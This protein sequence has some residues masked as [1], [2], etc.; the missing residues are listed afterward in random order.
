MNGIQPYASLALNIPT[1]RSDLLGTVANARMDPDLVGINVFGRG[2]NV[3]PTLGANIPV[4]DS[5]LFGLSAGYTYHG[6]YTKDAVINPAT[7]TPF[8]GL[9]SALKPGDDF[10][11]TG[12]AGYAQGAFLARVAGSVTFETNTDISGILLGVPY[13]GG[14][15]RSGNAYLVSALASYD[16]SQYWTSTLSGAWAHTDRN[17]VLFGNLPPLVAELFDSNT[18]VYQVTLDNKFQVRSDLIVGPTVGFLD[19]TNNSWVSTSNQYIA[20]KTK[21]TAGVFGTYNLFKDLALNGRVE[22]YWIHQGADQGLLLPVLA[23]NGW[24]VSLGASY[25][26]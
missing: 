6:D 21:W 9:T 16:W 2:W 24:L 1:G 12:S 23:D 22:H 20:A 17:N 14:L 26:W 19:R 15:Y 11:V 4:G 5:W 3:G 13:N 25:T 18:D 10:T 7:L 8:T